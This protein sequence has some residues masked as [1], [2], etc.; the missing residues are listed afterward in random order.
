MESEGK[1]SS[2]RKLYETVVSNVA[3]LQAKQEAVVSILRLA[4]VDHSHFSFLLS[5][6][7]WF[8]PSN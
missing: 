4:L 7:N 6:I 1:Q 8:C 5:Q 3:S 2:H